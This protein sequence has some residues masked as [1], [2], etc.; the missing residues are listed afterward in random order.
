MSLHLVNLDERTRQFMRDELT[1][2]EGNGRLYLSSRLTPK[3][4]LEWANL[5]HT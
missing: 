1:Q 4:R 3:G 5:L 2:D